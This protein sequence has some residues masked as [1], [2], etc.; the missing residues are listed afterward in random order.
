VSGSNDKTVRI[1][2]AQSGKQVGDPLTGHDDYV[3]SDDRRVRTWDTWAATNTTLGHNG[4]LI[5]NFSRYRLIWIPI[6]MRSNLF[7]SNTVIIIA[8]VGYTKI[9]LL[10]GWFG[11]DWPKCY[12]AP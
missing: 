7:H 6:P 1:W 5:D 4:W 8:K 3:R 11:R 9:S 10:C 12:I 2:D